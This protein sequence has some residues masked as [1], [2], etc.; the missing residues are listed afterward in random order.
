[1]PLFGLHRQYESGDSYSANLDSLRDSYGLRFWAL[2]EPA[3]GKDTTAWQARDPMHMARALAGQRG[4]LLPPLY[5]DCGTED[6]LLGQNDAFAAQLRNAGFSFT[7]QRW[8]GE[9]TWDYWRAHAAEAA[10][11]LA[12]RLSKE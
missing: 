9:H 5:L 1:M 10:T 3:F 12:R 11:W 8:P 7:Y 4:G 2:M 6:F